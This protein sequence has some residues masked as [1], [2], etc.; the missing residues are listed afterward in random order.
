MALP[1]AQLGYMPNINAPTHVPTQFRD[2]P[3]HK[4]AAQI[5]AQVGTQV[6][7]QGASNLMSPEFESRAMT[8]AAAQEGW[9]PTPA[10]MPGE[11]SWWAKAVHGP[12]VDRKAYDTADQQRF[13]LNKQGQQ[14][15][16]AEKL[17]AEAQK[18]TSGENTKERELRLQSEL[19]R[20]LQATEGNRLE[21][22]RNDI[23]RQGQT[24]QNEQFGKRLGL[25]QGQLDLQR[26][27]GSAH[28]QEQVEK[29]VEAEARS[30]LMNAQLTGKP[31]PVINE[32]VR[33]QL[34]AKIM[35]RFAAQYVAGFP[36]VGSMAPSAALPGAQPNVQ[37]A[38]EQFV[39]PSAPPPAP[40]QVS[41]AAPTTA[42]PSVETAPDITSAAR[43][44]MGQGGMMPI[45][46]QPSAPTVEP[47][48]DTSGINQAA[49]IAARRAQQ[50]AIQKW[51]SEH[52]IG[53]ALSG[54]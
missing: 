1:I 43:A 50:E 53:A 32:Q 25:E 19:A 34:R 22:E 39:T 37:Q 27:L 14:M 20:E 46:S 51:L 33:N 24:Q 41:S 44:F 36:S 54:R 6:A 7:S 10:D 29:Q 47:V 31:M 18:F 26:Y 16:H 28:V 3:W 40:V 23:S 21:Q 12:R 5:L 9:I 15:T 48:A 49:T 8:D 11:Q 2:N 30:L 35:Q 4:L 52:L 42:Q 38:A 13:E 17:Q 45:G